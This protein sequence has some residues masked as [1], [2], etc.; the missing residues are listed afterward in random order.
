MVVTNLI[1][2]SYLIN[3]TNL[4]T[5]YDIPEKERLRS[6]FYIIDFGDSNPILLKKIDIF[7]FFI[8]TYSYM[9]TRIL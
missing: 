1:N 9:W 3:M 5:E 6:K 7:N 2:T 4:I 8:N